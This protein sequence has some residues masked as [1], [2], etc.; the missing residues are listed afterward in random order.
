MVLLLTFAGKLLEVANCWQT[1]GSGEAT[2]YK[3]KKPHGMENGRL[4]EGTDKRT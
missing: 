3:R 1:A 4:I 2:N